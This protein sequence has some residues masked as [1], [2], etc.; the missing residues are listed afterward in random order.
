M[1]DERA[2]PE[3]V[4]QMRAGPQQPLVSYVTR[5]SR[6]WMTRTKLAAYALVVL[7][8]ISLGAVAEADQTDP[9]TTNG[10]DSGNSGEGGTASSVET[11]TGAAK[12]IV[13]FELPPA[14]GEAQPALSLGYNSQAGEGEA[15][16]GWGLNVPSIVR[17]RSADG[18]VQMT[19]I[20][21]V[22]FS[23]PQTTATSWTADRFE[24]RGRP[25]V[26]VCPNAQDNCQP[27]V[28]SIRPTLQGTA[29]YQLQVDDGS[30]IRFFL[31]KAEDSARWSVE[32]KSGLVET[33]GGSFRATVVDASRSPNL[34][35]RWH[36][37]KAVDINGNGVHY[38]WRSTLIRTGQ[39]PA[40]SSARGLPY[41]TDI[42]YGAKADNPA[43]EQDFFL[44]EPYEQ[45]V[46]LVW[47]LPEFRQQHHASIWAAKPDLRLKRVDV[48]SKPWDGS[49]ARR[50]VRRYHLSYYTHLDPAGNDTNPYDPELNVPL[51][52]H[53][54]LRSV[55]L[56]GRTSAV[57]I[58]ENE[59]QS[60]PNNSNGPTLPPTTYRYSPRQGG[61]LNVADTYSNRFSYPLVPGASPQTIDSI[62][63]TAV[64]DVN[65]DGWPDLVEGSWRVLRN[66]ARTAN[67]SPKFEEDCLEGPPAGSPSSTWDPYWQWIFSARKGLTIEGAWGHD[68]QGPSMFVRANEYRNGLSGLTRTVPGVDWVLGQILPSASPCAHDTS[69]YTPQTWKIARIPHDGALKPTGNSPSNQDRLVTIGDVDGDGLADGYV[70]TEG[71]AGTLPNQLGTPVIRFSRR[72][73]GQPQDIAKFGERVATNLLLEGFSCAGNL[74]NCTYYETNGDELKGANA[75]FDERVRA[76]VDLNGD[77]LAD[78]VGSTRMRDVGVGGQGADTW[79]K[80]FELGYYAGDGRGK[81]ACAE[82]LQSGVS[83][84]EDLKQCAGLLGQR[85][86]VAD[87]SNAMK[88]E[89][90]NRTPWDTG[91]STDRPLFHDINGD[92]FTD[93]IIPRKFSGPLSGHRLYFA[94]FL[95]E[96]GFRFRRYCAEDP[97]GNTCVGAQEAELQIGAGGPMTTDPFIRAT[98]LTDPTGNEV[99]FSPYRIAFGDLNA[100]GVEEILVFQKS[101]VSRL[102]LDASS[103]PGLLT[104][105]D[106]GFGGKTTFSYDTYQRHIRNTSAD[107]ARNQLEAVTNVVSSVTTTNGLSGLPARTQTVSFKYRMPAFDTWRRALVGFGEVVLNEQGGPSIRKRYHYAPCHLA[108]GCAATAEL[109]EASLLDGLPVSEEILD[110]DPTEAIGTPAVLRQTLNEYDSKTLGTA[111]RPRKS[112]FLRS[113]K[114]RL[115]G[116][117]S[118]P[119]PESVSVKVVARVGAHGETIVSEEEIV[120]WTSATARLLYKEFEYDDF[121]N[122]NVVRD[123]GEVVDGPVLTPLDQILVQ[124][125]TWAR[126][127]P[128]LWVWRVT[129]SVST[130]SAASS[131]PRHVRYHYRANSWLLETVDAE[132]VGSLGLSRTHPAGAVAPSPES[133]SVDGYVTEKRFEYNTRGQVVTMAGPWARS[134]PSAPLEGPC[135]KVAY[136][137][138][139][140][141]FPFETNRGGKA[142]LGTPGCVSALPGGFLTSYA[143]FDRGLGAVVVSA[144]SAGQ[145]TLI[146]RDDLGRTL[147][148][149]EPDPDAPSL[150]S[151]VARATVDYTYAADHLAVHTVRG[152]GGES[153]DYIDGLGSRILGLERTNAG[154]SPG[155]VAHGVAS[156]YSNGQPNEVFVPFPYG[157]SP[158]SPTFGSGTSTRVAYSY[159]RWGRPIQVA[160]L[161]SSSAPTILSKTVYGALHTTSYDA[162]GASTTGPHA[163][164]SVTRILDGHF[165]EHTIQVTAGTDAEVT[166]R[167]FNGN[168]EVIGEYRQHTAGGESHLRGFD[169]DSLGRMVRQW[170][171]NTRTGANTWS[172]AYDDAG[173]LV[174]TSDA[175]GCGENIHYDVLGRKLAEDYSPCTS[176]QPEYNAPDLVTGAGTESFY[177]YDTPAAGD[178]AGNP[179]A[180]P[181]MLMAVK[182]RGASTRYG[183][184]LRGR[185]RGASRQLAKPGVAAESLAERYASHWFR[186]DATFDL[187]DRTRKST[188][189]ADV[190]ELLVDGESAVSYDYGARGQVSSVGSSYGVLIASVARRAD[191]RLTDVV[192]GDAGATH[193]SF[194]YEPDARARLKTAHVR[195]GATPAIWS[196]PNVGPP[197]SGAEPT[198]Q[199]DFLQTSVDYDHVGNPVAIA[200]GLTAA[201]WP[202]G[203]RPKTYTTTYDDHYRVKRVAYGTGSDLRMPPYS[204]VVDGS[205]PVP[206][207]SR[208]ARM[209]QQ[210]FAYDWRGNILS[211]TSLDNGAVF[212]Q[213][214]GQQEHGPDASN[215]SD[216]HP[217]RLKSAKVG[218][219]ELL[220]VHYDDAGNMVDLF[221]KRPGACDGPACNHRFIYDWDEVGQLQRARR[222]DYATVTGGTPVYPT[223]PALDANYDLEYGYSGMQR[224]RKS[225]AE[226]SADEKHTLEV[227]PTLRVE[228]STF[229]AIGGE[230]Q[231]TSD[232]ETVYLAGLGRAHYGSATHPGAA[233]GRTRL[234]LFITDRLGSASVVLDHRTSEVIEKISYDANGN[235]ESDYRPTRWGSAREPYRFT[236]KEEDIEVGLTYFGA[237]YLSTNLRRWISPD[238]LTI[239][240]ASG[241]SNP[242]AYVRGRTLAAVDPW[243]LDGHEV[244]PGNYEFDDEP[245]KGRAPKPPPGPVAPASAPEVDANVGESGARNVERSLDRL[246]FG[247]DG[248]GIVHLPFGF[249]VNQLHLPAEIASQAPGAVARVLIDVAHVQMAV[250]GIRTN[251]VTDAAEHWAVARI[252]AASRIDMPSAGPRD[253]TRIAASAII[254]GAIGLAGGAAEGAGA[255]AEG[256]G[257]AAEAGV[258]A[259]AEGGSVGAMQRY[260]FEA[261]PKHPVGVAPRAGV[262][263]GPT[264]GQAALDSSVSIGPNTPRR[265]GID[266]DTG[267]FAVFDETYPGRGVF[268]G[269]VRGWDQLEQGMQ[270]ALRR[271]GMVNRRGGIVIGE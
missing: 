6:T 138:N 222:W 92:G 65:R 27:G 208:T 29:L 261:S 140:S 32:Y 154:A 199:Q 123:Y 174:G 207:M 69:T 76:L 255:A 235:A 59:L 80:D 135:V 175:R 201:E 211:S 186:T 149:S 31:H 147:W 38:V 153:Y 58:N 226:G 181:G 230:Y 3:E 270:N 99:D 141:H 111:D 139:Y 243:G 26:L 117:D 258:A 83:G 192:Y 248:H 241:D 193:G 214:L 63:N 240:G 150:L 13:D 24:W 242:Y 73:R 112:V 119:T 219:N 200:D 157:G 48:A 122:V 146:N 55:V 35:V 94:I 163:G 188:T 95:N 113:R 213:F 34:P 205:R 54:F 202:V 173:R 247:P 254:A 268:H 53:S 90:Q 57:E 260:A 266:Y 159:D 49:G 12:A 250:N 151:P 239:H 183:Y 9:T 64:V 217:D 40:T 145:L 215:P 218:N 232:N 155:W 62:Q 121:G 233:F 8:I 128:N 81:F 191:G 120:L 262:S 251:A 33:Y 109:D 169:Y 74:D 245:L 66:V 1:Q 5:S 46:S 18:F 131:P 114:I 269:H 67:P 167:Y 23:F 229:D 197:P 56:E 115:F 107:V 224:V 162:E 178:P 10:A 106:N 118:S 75:K 187:F 267:E 130:D 161:N 132:L 228:R 144:G 60:L 271:S 101:G 71:N 134:S 216:T 166:T 204:S 231:L 124:R 171:P 246:S 136:D 108:D 21:P 25:L 104:S 51:R 91:R 61:L 125:T 86:G 234:S 105:V 16:L 237:R 2:E 45:H 143:V 4:V 14:R 84:G 176:S 168:S 39:N 184:D 30:L 263:P 236:G 210:D 78:A 227:F 11:S 89:L 156:R 172:Y 41:L 158:T 264:N 129:D 28:E 98:P 198:R 244:S 87:G 189:G 221:V 152:D 177:I 102:W 220:S 100:D 182:D 77:G 195:R 79:H 22:P 52:G 72:A 185:A 256:F 43:A 20:A 116:P 82:A 179:A 180:A 190:P 223:L 15:G 209:T 126:V 137:G 238:P 85:F 127:V 259:E 36:L 196:N 96:E 249:S 37:S 133:R 19:D 203:A 252:D 88:I 164:N 142:I 42:Y 206:R 17:T 44:G 225:V 253:L 160:D 70:Q 170:E 68:H 93:I 50:Q 97:S 47:E 7:A 212:D 194:T 257:A 103:K 110:R 265:V 148:V 165:R